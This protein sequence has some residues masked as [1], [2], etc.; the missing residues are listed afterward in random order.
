MCYYSDN[1][2]RFSDAVISDILLDKKL[3]KKAKKIF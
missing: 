2:I 1:I 3:R